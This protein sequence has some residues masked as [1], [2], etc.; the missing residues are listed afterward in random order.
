MK[1]SCHIKSVMYWDHSGNN[2]GKIIPK[3]AP[4]MIVTQYFFFQEFMCH[5]KGN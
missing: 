2:Y 4:I 1:I 3:Y 5:D